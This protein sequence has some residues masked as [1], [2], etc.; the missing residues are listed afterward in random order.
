MWTESCKYIVCMA[1]L[2][3]LP[4]CMDRLTSIVMRHKALRQ[5]VLMVFWFWYSFRISDVNGRNETLRVCRNRKTINSP[6]LKLINFPEN[7]GNFPPVVFFL[8]CLLK[9]CTFKLL[10]VYFLHVMLWSI[11]EIF[12]LLLSYFLSVRVKKKNVACYHA[13]PETRPHPR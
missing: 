13:S 12:C 8:F 7:D 6:S 9:D 2:T 3:T 5:M 11:H 4:W 10:T 1:K